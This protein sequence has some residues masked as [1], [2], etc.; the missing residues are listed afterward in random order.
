MDYYQLLTNRVFG[1]GRRLIRT[2]SE[3]PEV[4]R[5]FPFQNFP[6][7]IRVEIWRDSVPGFAPCTFAVKRGKPVWQE[8]H[9][10][11]AEHTCGIT[12]T[13]ET[14][15]RISAIRALLLTCRES[16]D[17]IEKLYPQVLH[18]KSGAMRWN[19]ATDIFMSDPSQRLHFLQE[20]ST[21]NFVK[22]DFYGHWNKDV[23]NFGCFGER[24]KEIHRVPVEKYAP[25]SPVEESTNDYSVRSELLKEYPLAPSPN[26]D[27]REQARQSVI[28][29]RIARS[30]TDLLIHIGVFPNLRSL[31]IVLP[32]QYRTRDWLKKGASSGDLQMLSHTL[33]KIPGLFAWAPVPGQSLERH[34]LG[35][36]TSRTPSSTFEWLYETMMSRFPFFCSVTERNDLHTSGI[37]APNFEWFY[38]EM[39]NRLRF[40]CSITEREDLHGWGKVV[41]RSIRGNVPREKLQKLVN[42]PIY[43]MVEADHGLGEVTSWETGR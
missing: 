25:Y 21:S 34:L 17:E 32:N 9:K 7:E 43:I 8:E 42:L 5:V 6:G 14:Q 27:P 36:N 19:S 2:K 30:W 24:L 40:F 15:H 28:H 38:E 20:S 39:R 13:L 18:L 23:W 16:R 41:V 35:D 4:D 12:P 22:W 33:C 29:E 1:H 37:F 26:A 10:N 31:I 11:Y 3:K